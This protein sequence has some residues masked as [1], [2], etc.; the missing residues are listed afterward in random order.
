LNQQSR[1]IV[2][3]V[4][5]MVVLGTWMYFMP[6]P[7][8]TPAPAAEPVAVSNLSPSESA[9]FSAK[10]AKAEKSSAKAIAA[11]HVASNIPA[12][13]TTIET[14]DYVA[15]FSNK[16][17]VLTGFRL[18]KYENRATHQPIDLVNPD[19]THPKPFSIS[20]GPMPDL[21]QKMF[22]VE[23]SSKTI[24]GKEHA[25]LVFR[26]VDAN[27]TVLEKTFG[28]NND[29]YLIQFAAKVSQTG[30]GSVPT[31]N[32][33]VEWADTLGVEE[34][35]GTQSRSGG[36]RVATLA[37]GHSPS[38]ETEKSSKESVEIPGPITWTALANQFFVAAMVPDATSGGNSVKVVRDYNAY[39]AATVGNDTPAVNANKFAPRPLL[40]FDAPSLRSGESFERKLQVFFGPQDYEILKKQ[41]LQLESVV[42]FGFFGF[43][44]VYM[45]ELLK[46]GFTW[47]HNWGLAIILL[48]IVVKLILW[49]PTHNSYKSMYLMQQKMKEIQPKLEALKRK[50]PDDKQKQQ[51]EQ[52][53]IYNQAGVNPMSGC[54]P[55]LLQMPV[56]W[57]LYATLGHSIEL[58][59]ANFLWLHDLSLKDP[60]YVFPLLMGSTMLLQQKVSGQMANQ[61]AGQQKVMLWLMPGLL[62]FMSFQWPS[63]LLVYWVTTNVL[64]MIQQKIVN[65]EIKNTQKK[66]EG[67][68]S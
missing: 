31:S 53:A 65:R 38:S 37:A 32:L 43:L 58:R 28:F 7:S 13:T 44:S 45:L 67:M 63:G 55:L 51:Q 10:E 2:F 18:K 47:A 23:G 30:H 50:Y 25:Q 56:F 54:L 64:S 5:S 6:T 29:S 12:S 24:T 19:E 48:S 1:T 36:Y 46:W 26:T 61:A 59:G 3:I 16:G 49:I 20:Y 8:Q 33:T 27:G 9:K 66:D 17:A 34:N 60:F 39:A 11:V 62:T 4:T 57:A 52:M 21:N 22:Q 41:G 14:D 42:D 40:N 68:K 35:T 15:T